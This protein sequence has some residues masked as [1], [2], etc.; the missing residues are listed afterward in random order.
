MNIQK[1]YEKELELFM[2]EKLEKIINIPSPSGYTK[3]L[4]RYL[5]TESEALGFQT[6]LTRR[7][8]LI[9]TLSDKTKNKRLLAAHCDTLGAMVRTVMEDGTLKLLQIGGYMLESVEGEYCTIHTRKGK[10]YT[11][12]ILTSA[13]S[14]HA[15]PDSARELKRTDDAMRIRLDEDVHSKEDVL[16]KTEIRRGDFISFEPRFQAFENGYIKS[17]HLDNKASVAVFMAVMKAVAEAVIKPKI[18]SQVMF[19]NYEEVGFGASYIPDNIYE[20]IAVD[21]GSVGDDLEGDEKKV[22]I[23]TKDMQGPYDFDLVTKLIDL[24][25]KEELDYVVECYRRYKSDTAAAIAGGR[26]IRHG[27]VGQGV[28]AS[29]HMERTHIHGMIQNF[30][31][32]ASYIESDNDF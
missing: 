19:T 9:V 31:L 23:V 28:Q 1:E 32:L 8:A 2:K 15:Y 7:G 20:M 22:S 13:P 10:K 29:H 14:V 24:A 6:E 11:G 5:K 17:R 12:T 27:L 26:N 30:K 25:E 3:E 16:K 4:I 21:M 18:G